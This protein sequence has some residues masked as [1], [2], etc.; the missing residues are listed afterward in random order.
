MV[1]CNSSRREPHH[2]LQSKSVDRESAMNPAIDA[3]NKTLNDGDQGD[4]QSARR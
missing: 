4:L 3:Y 1:D 2:R